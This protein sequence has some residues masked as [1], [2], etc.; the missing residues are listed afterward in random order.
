MS[1][2]ILIVDDAN[3][4]RQLLSMTLRNAGCN[5]V[6]ACDGQDGLTKLKANSVNMIF[7]DLNMPVMNGLEFIKAVKSLPQ[8]KFVP[9]VMLTTESEE[10]KKREGQAAGAKAWI[11]KPFKPETIVAVMKKIIG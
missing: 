4:V 5:V 2:S 6:E 7:T 10:S 11:I 1:K 9:I 3:T 8:F